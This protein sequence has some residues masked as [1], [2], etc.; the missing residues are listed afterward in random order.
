MPLGNLTSQFFANVYLN[1]LDQFIKHKLKAKYYIR[2]VDDFVILH[3]SREQ[4]TKWKI[5]IDDFIKNELKI[6]LHPDKSKVLQLNR[7]VGFLGFRIFFHH[8]LIKKKNFN[9]FKIKFRRLFDDY[10][11]GLIGK[12][13]AIEILQGWLAY[14]SHANTFR[15][16]NK[17]IKI[18]DELFREDYNPYHKELIKEEKYNHIKNAEYQKIIPSQDKTLYLLKKKLTV[19][20][21]AVLRNVKEGTIWDHIVKLIEEKQLTVFDVLPKNK[22][23]KILSKIKSKEDKLKEIKE[24]LNS[25]SITYHEI[26]CVLA[27]AN[28]RR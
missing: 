1:E 21:I 25:I 9:H 28:S 10:R 22:V 3:S 13:K 6:G 20:E 16:R 4:L 15:Y 27:M 5:E 26:S 2:Y 19:K 23:F 17:I 14:V 7:G 8:K 24:R 18:F 11:K 12:E